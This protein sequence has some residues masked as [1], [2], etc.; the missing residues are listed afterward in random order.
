MGLK[1]IEMGE[2]RDALELACDDPRAC[3]SATPAPPSV[4]PVRLPPGR[5]RLATR[6]SETGSPEIKNAIGIVEEVF[7]A[8]RAAGSDMANIKSTLRSTKSAAIAGSRSSSTPQW[9]S[10]VTFRPSV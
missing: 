9:Y 7:F 8:I 2:A 6:P 1:I 5:A 3:R 10:T 4:T